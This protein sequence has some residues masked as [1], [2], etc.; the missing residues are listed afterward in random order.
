MVLA[1]GK[2]LV[3]GTVDPVDGFLLKLDS[4]GVKD[5][6]FGTG[7]SV[8][9]PFNAVAAMALDAA[10]NLVF[11]GK[12]SAGYFTLN[13]VLP[14]GTPDESF[15]PQGGIAL[16]TVNPVAIVVRPDGRAVVLGSEVSSGEK[17]Y[18]ARFWM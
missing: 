17:L 9:I 16:A 10:L 18:L 4:L 13:R 8:K 15:L 7:G 5:T 11:A 1:D 6:S 14:N 2:I 3:G 12:N